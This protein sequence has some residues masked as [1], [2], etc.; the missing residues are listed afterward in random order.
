MVLLTLLLVTTPESGLPDDE[1]Q[2]LLN[3]S[4]RPEDDARTWTF[5]EYDS[6]MED[7]ANQDAKDAWDAHHM[8]LWNP[9]EEDCYDCYEE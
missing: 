1:P 7:I 9:I 3:P 5:D 6:Y 8:Q 4:A 2:P